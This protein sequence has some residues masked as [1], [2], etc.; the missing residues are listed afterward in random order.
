MQA[1]ILVMPDFTRSFIIETDAS[2]FGLSAVLLQ[3]GHPFAYF[4]KVLGVQA[5]LK[6]IYEKE[7]MA[8]VLA[9]LKRSIISWEGGL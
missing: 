7:L 3:K 5:R 4:S 1:P 2:T 8:I 9:V 6:S